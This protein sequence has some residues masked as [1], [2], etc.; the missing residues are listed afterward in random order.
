VSVVAQRS[1]HTQKQDKP[2]EKQITALFGC[3]HSQEPSHSSKNQEITHRGEEIFF[4]AKGGLRS[5]DKGSQTQTRKNSETQQK[6][7][8]CPAFLSLTR[9]PA[10]REFAQK[11]FPSFA[12]GDQRKSDW[13]EGVPKENEPAEVR[14]AILK[15]MEA[16]QF[17]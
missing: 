3:P 16:I 4:L 6:P 5:Q 9:Q 11:R 10:T 1:A 15:L 2:H 7:H 8:T 14:P 17:G 12:S 13:T